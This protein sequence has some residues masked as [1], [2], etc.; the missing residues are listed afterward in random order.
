M[1]DVAYS[2]YFIGIIQKS[3]W[4]LLTHFMLLIADW[5]IENPH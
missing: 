5:H 3:T 1:L 4:T 2:V